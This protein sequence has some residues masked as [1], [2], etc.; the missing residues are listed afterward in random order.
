MEQFNSSNFEKSKSYLLRCLYVQDE[1]SL[2]FDQLDYLINQGEINPLVG[3]LGCRSALRYGIERPNLFC[4]DPLKYVL[5]TD[6]KNKCDFEKVFV[7]TAITIL[8]ENRVPYR[9]QGL[10]TNGRQ[11]FGNLFN[12][13][14]DFT[15]EIR[16]IIHSEVEKYR[17]Y[18]KDSEEGLIRKWPADYSISSWLISMKSGGELRPHM[19][20]AGWVSGSIYINVPPK[21][22]TDSGN[23]VVC[24]EDE[25]SVRGERGISKNIIDVVSGSLALFPASLLH[26]TIPFESEEERIVL[27]F[28]VMP[29]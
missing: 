14:H 9:A 17:A 28:D 4:K 29:K 21:S 8:S 26:Y 13:E 22:K 5:K 15:E 23:L 24:I 18:F 19:H 2:F 25:E 10:L 1:Q 6:L 7:K 27:A 20:E 16:K 12:L 3:S 11:T